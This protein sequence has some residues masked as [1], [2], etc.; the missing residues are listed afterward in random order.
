MRPKNDETTV[1][2]SHCSKEAGMRLNYVMLPL[3]Y[4]TVCIFT[5]A[6]A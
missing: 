4:R 2:K 3:N 1:P 6:Q 5:E